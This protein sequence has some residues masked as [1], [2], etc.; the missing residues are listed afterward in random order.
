MTTGDRVLPLVHVQ[1]LKLYTQREP[2]TLV[3]RVTSVLKSDSST[4]HMDNQYSEVTVTGKVD[5]DNR[6]ADISRWESDYADML[7]KETGLND[8]VQFKIETGASSHLRGALQN[9]TSPFE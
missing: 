8:L 7:T 5:S 6:D 2:E 9:H 3:H 4:D 1:L